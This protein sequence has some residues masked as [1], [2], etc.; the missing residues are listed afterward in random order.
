MEESVPVYLAFSVAKGK[1][2]ACA[3]RALMPGERL[4]IPATTYEVVVKS[5]GDADDGA[6]DH[7][8]WAQFSATYAELFPACI[9]VSEKYMIVPAS[10]IK[11]A[12]ARMYWWAFVPHHESID[13]KPANLLLNIT[14]A[15]STG[16]LQA[17]EFIVLRKVDEGDDLLCLSQGINTNGVIVTCPTE[18]YLQLCEP[19]TKN[20]LIAQI[21]RHV[22]LA[23]APAST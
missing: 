20:Q 11:P 5:D 22:A 15:E 18:Q 8:K 21:M 14:L 12:N 17:I 4:R 3:S 9:G 10:V 2:V 7:L 13:H 16:E 19:F 6:G 1:H 23:S